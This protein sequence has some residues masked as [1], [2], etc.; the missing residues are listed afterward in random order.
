LVVGTT[1]GFAEGPITTADL[2][3]IIKKY[4]DIWNNDAKNASL[5]VV[6]ADPGDSI[7]I[8]GVTFSTRDKPKAGMNIPVRAH[9]I[10][11]NKK[12]V[13]ESSL[14]TF[15][16]EYGHARYLV[17]HQLHEDEIGSETE[18]IRFSLEALSNEGYINL[19]YREA[20]N[21]KEMAKEEPYKSAV[22]RLANDPL[23]KK[24]GHVSVSK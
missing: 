23:W 13:P 8:P 2:Q 14:S 5:W 22:A 18:A 16:H 20:E 3:R 7:A 1:N 10:V 24:Y 9:L 21:V 12:M 6:R 11:L 19:A 4:A 17:T 15:F